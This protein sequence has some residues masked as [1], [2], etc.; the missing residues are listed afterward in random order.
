MIAFKRTFIL[1]SPHFNCP[2]RKGFSCGT[3]GVVRYFVHNKVSQ[4]EEQR[5]ELMKASENKHI[6]HN[7]LA[8]L[9]RC[10]S[11][12]ACLSAK[13]ATPSHTSPLRFLF[14]YLPVSCA[15]HCSRACQLPMAASTDLGHFRALER[16]VHDFLR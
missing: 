7:D 14:C 4:T 2:A 5:D 11:L 9:F 3:H 16:I 10:H 6:L 1:T 8:G 13:G 12:P 15:K